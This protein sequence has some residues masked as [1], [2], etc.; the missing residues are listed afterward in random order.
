MLHEVK[1]NC[2]GEVRVVALKQVYLMRKEKPFPQKLHNGLKKRRFFANPCKYYVP[3]TV[4]ST[5]RNF[6]NSTKVQ[7]FSIILKKQAAA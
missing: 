6:I 7:K 2:T 4:A 3:S 5:Q 1:S